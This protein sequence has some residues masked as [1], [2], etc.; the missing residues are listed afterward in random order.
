MR[1]VRNELL[2]LLTL[3]GVCRT[4]AALRPCVVEG[5][6]FPLTVMEWTLPERAFPITD[7]GAKLGD[8]PVT[9]PIEKAIAAAHAAG[10]G[11][12]TVPAGRWVTGAFALKDNVALVLD[13]KATLYFPDD[14][15]IAMRAPLQ[16][17]GRP[18]LTHRALVGAQGCTNVAVVGGTFAAGVDYWHRGHK[19][20]P[21]KGFPRPQFFKF[22]RCANVRLENFRI[23]ESP[24][25]TLVFEV[26]SD[27]ILRDIDSVCTGPNTDGL[28]LVSCNRALVER[29]SL[30]QTDDGYTIKSG[31]N[32]AGRKR[33]IPCQN[34]VIRN[35]TVVHCGSLLGV[36]SEVS[37]GIRNIHVANCTVQEDVARILSLKTN[38]HRGAF[39]ENISMENVTARHAD[40]VF[41][42]RMFYDGNPNKELPNKGKLW[43]TRIADIRIRN[44]VC[45]EARQA[46]FIDGDEH[47][48]PTGIVAENIRVGKI[49]DQ[50]I[51]VK[52]A[53]DAIVRD[54]REDPSVAESWPDADKAPV[55]SIALM[56]KSP[57]AVFARLM[58]DRIR[59]ESAGQRPSCSLIDA[60]PPAPE[61]GELFDRAYRVGIFRSLLA[62]CGYGSDAAPA[63][64]R[65]V[66]AATDGTVAALP[67][68]A[69]RLA[70]DE[71]AGEVRVTLRN[72][73]ATPLKDVAVEVH[74][75]PGPL[76]RLQRFAVPTLGPGET[77]ARVLRIGAGDR[78]FVHGARL[79]AAS[80]D[81][82]REGVRTRV[83]ATARCPGP[84]IFP[85]AR[86][87]ARV[88][89]IVEAS[90]VD[91]A[92]LCQL[93]AEKGSLAP[94]GDAPTLAWRA[95]EYPEG[96]FF[97]ISGPTRR[98]T[99]EERKLVDANRALK[100]AVFQFVAPAFAD[101]RLRTNAS[102]WDRDA[103]VFLNGERI[104]LKGKNAALPN[105][106]EG[107]NR[108]VIATRPAKGEYDE[109]LLASVYTWYLY[110]PLPAVSF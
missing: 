89:G 2:L 52:N 33:N 3:V 65:V 63:P 73:G 66:C 29:C 58:E 75:P 12:V 26:S 17:N 86:D 15:V 55:P 109:C 7:Y 5:A 57:V 8:A 16:P 13:E 84:K 70:P 35:C 1:I 94:L 69:W 42:I 56:E 10:G 43:L 74:L 79:Y 40:S 104:T 71:A 105:V 24:A 81:F 19:L 50:L 21:R 92:R 18:K 88:T 90:G 85:L 64:A 100:V 80:A 101:V 98:Y 32:A 102:I 72:G 95:V 4:D 9:E 36:G 77:C 59:C 67:G 41:G 107:V 44:I 91:E 20:N 49:R 47:L 45:A 48:P 22:T 103:R 82:A 38:S 37:G 96:D 60:F 39:I 83:W 54:V 46:I 78:K 14:P 27:I 23:R 87:V 110:N 62:E 99:P 76:T 61:K 106:R 108:L 93:S 25:W 28:D 34:V 68:V 30:D 31:M 6:P 53:P 11:R 51:R 97:A